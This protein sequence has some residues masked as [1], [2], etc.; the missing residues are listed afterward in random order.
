MYVKGLPSDA[1]EGE[2]E[3][4]FSKCGVIKLDEEGRPKVKIYSDPE[5]G[6]PKG[7]G[8]VTY[9][10]RPSVELACQILDGAQFRPG[11]HPLSVSEAKFEMKGE[12]YVKKKSVPEAAAPQNSVRLG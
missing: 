4:Y 12:A 11:S 9:L 10:K 1:V 7:D 3:E 6:A 2:V 5:T 8:L